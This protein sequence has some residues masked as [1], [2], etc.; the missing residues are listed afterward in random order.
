MNASNNGLEDKYNIK[1]SLLVIDNISTNTNNQLTPDKIPKKESIES[2]DKD[3]QQHNNNRTQ[4]NIQGTIT[5]ATD[6]N[7][8]ET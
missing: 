3:Q 1:K 2:S 8:A 5:P 4:I 7:N 6:T